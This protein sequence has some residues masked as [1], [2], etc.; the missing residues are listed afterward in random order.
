MTIPLDIRNIGEGHDWNAKKKLAMDVLYL[1]CLNGSYTDTSDYVKMVTFSFPSIV[2]LCLSE[3]T[4]ILISYGCMLK[5][6]THIEN[7]Y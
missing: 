3:P 6:K 4:I 5:E 7:L 1:G 2:S